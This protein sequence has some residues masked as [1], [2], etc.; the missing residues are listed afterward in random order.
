[1]ASFDV[2]VLVVAVIASVAAASGVIGEPM[3][4]TDAM[5]LCAS[6]GAIVGGVAG[7]ALLER[8]RE[9]GRQDKMDSVQLISSTLPS[10]YE[11]RPMLWQ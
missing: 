10:R 9:L 1:M 3:G 6:L 8:A 5:L 4:A 7:V 2:D 11:A